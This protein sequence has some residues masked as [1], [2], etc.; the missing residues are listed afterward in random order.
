MHL[1]PFKE[2]IAMSKEK[3][4]SAM[5]PIRARQMRS[6]A[7]LE[8]HKLDA[9]IL[10]KEISVQ[11][12]CIDKDLNLTVLIDR[13]DKIA[14]LERRKNQYGKVLKQLFPTKDEGGE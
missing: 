9:E 6:M 14:V 2:I 13:L 4:D 5:A 3:L 12:M 7:E 11:E 10:E 8:M 1:K